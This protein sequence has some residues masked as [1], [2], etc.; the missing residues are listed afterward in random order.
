MAT[1]TRVQRVNKDNRP[2]IVQYIRDGFTEISAS[3]GGSLSIIDIWKIQ[4][5]TQKAFGISDYQSQNLTWEQIKTR[6][7]LAA[8]Q[9][10]G[11]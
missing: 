6:V 1:K 9:S 11:E 4:F 7:K 10:G 2:A 8:I 3:K 5:A